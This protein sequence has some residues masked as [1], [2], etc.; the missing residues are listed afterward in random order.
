[1]T[2]DQENEYL[3]EVGYS[4]Y[5]IYT[6]NKNYHGGEMPKWNDLPEKI[7]GAWGNAVDAIRRGITGRGFTNQSGLPSP[8]AMEAAKLMYDTDSRE[9][10]EVIKLRARIA[11]LGGTK[12]AHIR[13]RAEAI[14]RIMSNSPGKGA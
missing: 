5:S 4:A 12:E 7:R 9:P 13:A 11:Q 8:S 10:D 3:A 14:D 2:K 6:G 1:M